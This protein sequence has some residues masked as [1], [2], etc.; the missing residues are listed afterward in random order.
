[1]PLAKVPLSSSQNFTTILLSFAFVLPSPL[2]CDVNDLLKENIHSAS[3]IDHPVTR[4]ES[5]KS[6]ERKRTPA[7]AAAAVRQVSPF[8]QPIGL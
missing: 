8:G 1:M 7:A 5:G 6:E 2:N 3:P 4:G